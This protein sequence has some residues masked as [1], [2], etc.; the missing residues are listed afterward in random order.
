MDAKIKI[1]FETNSYLTN[2]FIFFMPATVFFPLFTGAVAQKNSAS[3]WRCM[4][5]ITL[6]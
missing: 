5:F 6:L 3:Y 1:F 4:A 2:I